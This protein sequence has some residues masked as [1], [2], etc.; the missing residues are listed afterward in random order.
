[1][2]VCDVDYGDT[3]S[4]ILLA[5]CSSDFTI[6]LWDT[7][8]DYKNVKTLRGHDH[9]VSA[10]RFIPSGNLLA[11]ASRDMKVI[12]WNVINGYRVKTIEDHT[13]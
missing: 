7:T 1:M 4:G 6:K 9:I 11:S 12:L 5:S 8:D 3:S 10:V 13:G 2:A